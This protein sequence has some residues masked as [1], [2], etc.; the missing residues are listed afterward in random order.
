[1]I[2]RK[3]LNIGKD[4]I[5]FKAFVDQQKKYN[6]C[7][8][9]NVIIT[10]R[11]NLEFFDSNDDE[12]IVV[13]KEKQFQLDNYISWADI[14]IV[15]C[16]EDHK[17]RIIES[18]PD[19]KIVVWAGWGA[20]Y[21]NRFIG[22]EYRYFNWQTHKAMLLSDYK[23]PLRVL[24]KTILSI[25]SLYRLKKITVRVDG[26]STPCN[27][28]FQYV[29]NILGNSFRAKSVQIRYSS[30][31]KYQEKGVS[32]IGNNIIIGNSADPTNNHISIIN[33]LSNCCIDNEQIIFIPLSYG[34]TKRYVSFVKDYAKKHLD[35][36]EIV[37]LEERLSK[38]EYFS[39]INTCNIGVYA[40][41]RQQAVGNIRAMIEQGSNVYLSGISPLYVFLKRSGMQIKT[42]KELPM[43][44]SR[45]KNRMHTNN[46]NILND[47][48]SKQRIIKE[49]EELISGEYG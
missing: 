5:H 32:C 24:K 7:E 44:L 4:S 17:I 31:E 9:K 42:I 49:F 14:I 10:E 15:H 13:V 39:I 40:H 1:M 21:Y 33:S 34:G 47:L 35:N 12:E 16:L 3:V 20:D 18:I 46:L 29:K 11:N 27:T 22:G 45:V 30:N 37:F 26:F 23:Y 43:D 6:L 25:Q 41:S 2:N 8:Y 38:E 48:F 28:E 19:S 36:N